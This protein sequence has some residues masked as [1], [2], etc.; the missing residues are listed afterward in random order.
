RKSEIFTTAADG[1]STVEVH[2]L[3]GERSMV[4]DNI[5]LGKFYLTGLPPAPRGL[6]QIEV[7]FDIDASG[8]LTVTATDKGTGKSEK[9]TIMAPQRLSKDQIDRAM[10]DAESHA[11][12]DRRAKTR[13][14][15]RN[16]AGG[17]RQ[18]P[19]QRT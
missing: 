19:E 8:I 13:G 2:V 15:T 14:R 16:K 9:L 6:P 11:E 7:T 1:Q 3:Q 12:E 5:S 18:S 4:A 17:V 10:R